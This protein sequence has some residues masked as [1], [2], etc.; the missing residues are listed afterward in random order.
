MGPTPAI[1]SPTVALQE[2]EQIS[3]STRL[4]GITGCRASESAASASN[5]HWICRGI[6][7]G[8]LPSSPDRHATLYIY[9]IKNFGFISPSNMLENLLY[10]LTF[11]ISYV[12]NCM[13]IA[14]M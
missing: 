11:F 7:S 2:Q 13:F 12:I 3:K 4:T 6:S 5:E 9:L 1:V 14:A 10:F 8:V